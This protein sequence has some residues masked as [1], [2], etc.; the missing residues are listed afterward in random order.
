MAK[1]DAIRRA[2]DNVR[3][4]R[5]ISL[6]PSVLKVIFDELRALKNEMKKMRDNKDA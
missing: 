1:W 2:R 6:M 3:P 5:P 4:K